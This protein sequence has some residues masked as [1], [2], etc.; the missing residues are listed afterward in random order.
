MARPLNSGIGLVVLFLLLGILNAQAICAVAYASDYAAQ[1][2]VPRP[3]PNGGP[4]DATYLIGAQRSKF[5]ALNQKTGRID[6]S[7][8]D[9]T[10]VIQNAIDALS[11]I[12]GKVYITPGTYPVTQITLTGSNIILESESAVLFASDNGIS[13]REFPSGIQKTSDTRIVMVLNSAPVLLIDRASQVTVRNIVIDGNPLSRS[14]NRDGI[15][16][17]DSTGVLVENCEIRN[18]EGS[19]I[20]TRSSGTYD[21]SDPQNSNLN[22]RDVMIKGCRV[23]GT[24]TNP[25]YFSEGVKGFGYEV[26]FSEGVHIEN[27]VAQDCGESMFRPEYSRH[28]DFLNNTGNTILRVTSGE[29]FD[30]YRSDYVVVRGN[31]IFDP[32]GLGIFIYEYCRNLLIENNEIRSLSPESVQVSLHGIGGFQ[33]A[34]IENVRFSNNSISGTVELSNSYLKNVEFD[35]N[36]IYSLRAYPA[37]ETPQVFENITFASN[38]FLAKSVQAAVVSIPVTFVANSFMN[39]V[40]L[41]ELAAG[42][43]ILQNN[44]FTSDGV[45][46]AA[47]IYIAG[48]VN[49]AVL[50]NNYFHDITYQ[51]IFVTV[52]SGLVQNGLLEIVGNRFKH[53][54]FVGPQDTVVFKASSVSAIVMTSNIFEWTPG[55]FAVYGFGVSGTVADNVADKPISLS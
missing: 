5:F 32:G 17:W 4:A 21:L 15:L 48:S 14:F 51:A 49:H 45:A 43:A 28:V 42:T 50:E 52:D 46:Y 36:S 30:I 7:G 40:E 13:T 55:T 44:E 8:H 53:N 10:T 47:G 3:F 19:G 11:N 2:L 38:T 1:A 37:E 25:P 6:Y 23:H 9:A 34:P 33:S 16:I 27:S 18:V 39:R 22:T 41:R 29:V 24:R 20:R 12:G 26:E 54:G 31:R 35:S